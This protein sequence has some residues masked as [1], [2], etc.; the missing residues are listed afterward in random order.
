MPDRFP[1][2]IGLDASRLQRPSVSV[3]NPVSS[4]SVGSLIS[5]SSGATYNGSK[6]GL[7]EPA[8]GTFSDAT[9]VLP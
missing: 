1:F 4:L 2:S 7:S 3:S 6:V 5:Q 9:A 8:V